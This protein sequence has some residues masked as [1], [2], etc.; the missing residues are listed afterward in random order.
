MKFKNIIIDAD[1]CIKIGGSPK[2]RF[3]EILFSYADKIYMHKQYMM[4]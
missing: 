1:I 3:L 2:Y 4:K